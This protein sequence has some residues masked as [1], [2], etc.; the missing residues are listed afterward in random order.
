MG[1]PHWL[2][3]SAS[4][5]IL[6]LLPAAGTWPVVV[7]RDERSKIISSRTPESLG[8]RGARETLEY[9][10]QTR[11]FV[12]FFFSRTPD[13]TPRKKRRLDAEEAP[14]G[15][16]GCE[17]R[18]AR[19]AERVH[20]EDSWARERLDERCQDV[21]RL[22]RRMQPVAGIFPLDDIGNGRRGPL[23]IALEEQ[24]GALVVVALTGWGISKSVRCTGRRTDKCE[25]RRLEDDTTCIPVG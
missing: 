19:A 3:A 25:R 8:I 11:A 20:D 16:L 7:R 23:R 13:R 14:S 15:E 17:Q 18:G 9:C 5:R 12:Q 22:L 24:I 2:R 21:Q 10:S 1:L 6:S 4:Q